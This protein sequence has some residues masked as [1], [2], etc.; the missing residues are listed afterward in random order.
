M[1][2]NRPQFWLQVR[3]DYI[4]DNFDNLLSYL[5]Q[6]SYDPKEEH[7]D[8]E[9]TLR[10]MVELSDELAE[11]VTTTPFYRPLGLG[12]EP[13]AV[14]RLFCATILAANK[15]GRTLHHLIASL[16]DLVVKAGL[17]IK[18]DPLVRLYDIVCDCIRGK[19]LV[20]CGFTWDDIVTEQL[21]CGLFVEK[22]IQM[23]FADL[24]DDAA[25]I[26]IEN[27]GLFMVPRVG[28]S[29]LVVANR[30]NYEKM[31]PEVQ[32]HLPNV[33]DVIVPKREFEKGGDFDSFYKVTTRLLSAQDQ[34]KA[35]TRRVLN[36]Y[37]FQDCFIVK[38][39]NKR[40]IRIEAETIDPDYS[41]MR[42]KVF[43]NAGDKR[44]VPGSFAEEIKEGDY[45]RVC[46]AEDPNY[47]FEIQYPFE[48]F[49]RKHACGLADMP[50]Y[51]RFSTSYGKGTEWV[52]QDG[53][54]VGIDNGKLKDLTPE[55][56][57]QFDA[58][59]SSHGVLEL[60]LYKK[61]PRDD[62]DQFF[63]YAGIENLEVPEEEEKFFFTDADRELVL[64][65]LEDCMEEGKIV[66]E[67]GRCLQFTSAQRELCIPLVSVLA[68]MIDQGLPTSRARLE[69][70]TAATMLCK[71]L[72]LPGEEA[73]MD[74]ERRY[75]Y[76]Q[77]MF[78]QNKDLPPL[79]HSKELEGSEEVARRERII[80]TLRSYRKKEVARGGVELKSKKQHLSEQVGALVTASN[81]LIDIIDNLELNNIKNAI[82][83]ALSVEDEY[84]SI[85]DER[86]HYGMESISLE[87]KTSVVFPPTNRRRL[88][89]VVSDPENQK[90]AIIKAVNGFLNSR[91]GGE[92]L[93]GVGDDGY[94]RGLADDM[95]ELTSLHYIP[96]P[97]L[98][99]YRTYVQYILDHAFIV[100]GGEGKVSS[101][102]ISRMYIKYL[103]EV[104]AEG[105]EIMRI[106]IQ[107]YKGEIV[108]LPADRPE[109][110]EES[111]VRL[112]GRT[113]PV[114]P[115][116]AQE[117]KTY[118]AANI[119]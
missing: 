4:F 63:L 50:L 66:E 115:T 35:S 6:Y 81:S 82:A 99:H 33:M 47:T 53:L 106:Q 116:L 12:Y 103:L 49:Y 38:V 32:L 94:A 90:W 9:S 119:G 69:Y 91:S 107:P 43:L 85:L 37:T 104:D 56:R 87:F 73:Y 72:E 118:K 11:K 77:V 111:Y 117:I 8:Y 78:A 95:Q 108:T 88:F 25:T 114:T 61:P 79:V 42:G 40:G 65:F 60:R 100:N 55:E 58:I 101:T 27:R 52:T 20:R 18:A 112:S 14:I 30:V 39:V 93:L 51:A 84:V 3:K 21:Q 89:S 109:W 62:G 92:L 41:Y 29:E 57:E 36:N 26:F 17:E 15:A 71:V 97:T 70:I 23:Q 68:R 98:D 48:T 44:P 1:A 59:C 46:I 7:P 102:D 13:T 45:L 75:L 105:K 74:H 83:R 5:R 19:R 76:S 16:V 34:V 86:T 64:L 110:M 24:P 31:T 96:S 10:C 54:H 28:I 22:F 80:N 2:T 113:V 67:K